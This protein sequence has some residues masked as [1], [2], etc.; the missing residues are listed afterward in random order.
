MG[1]V[2]TVVKAADS[3]EPTAVTAD[4]EGT[5]EDTLLT[6]VDSDPGAE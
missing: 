4:L 1:T 6:G 2:D 5:E 3:P